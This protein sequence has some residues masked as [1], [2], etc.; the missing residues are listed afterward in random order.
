MYKKQLAPDIYAVLRLY[1]FNVSV[2]LYI[3][4]PERLNSFYLQY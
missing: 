2:S 4:T 3:L 1:Y